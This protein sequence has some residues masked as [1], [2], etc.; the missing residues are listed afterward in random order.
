MSTPGRVA[1]TG[2]VVSLRQTNT[3]ID[4]QI[5]FIEGHIQK[6]EADARCLAHALE[7]LGKG[8]W[9]KTHVQAYGLLVIAGDNHIAHIRSEIAALQQGITNIQQQ[10]REAPCPNPQ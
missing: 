5:A 1:K 4:V 7:E 6:Y 3:Q 2:R 10:Q 8:D 9:G